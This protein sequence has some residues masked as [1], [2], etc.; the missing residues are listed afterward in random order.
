MSYK[1]AIFKSEDPYFLV[2]GSVSQNPMVL[3]VINVMVAHGI[4]LNFIFRIMIDIAT[5]LLYKSISLSDSYKGS[6]ILRP[7]L[8]ITLGS[9]IPYQEIKTIE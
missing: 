4:H 7:K 6:Y 2:I 9:I 5:I 8:P 3:L 1:L